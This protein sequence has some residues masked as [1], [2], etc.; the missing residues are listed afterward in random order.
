VCSIHSP[1][2][3]ITRHRQAS[4]FELTFFFSAALRDRVT[5]RIQSRRR[6]KLADR[7][8]NIKVSHGQQAVASEK[9]DAFASQDDGQKATER[10]RPDKGSA[11][12][13][14][15]R[16]LYWIYERRL[17][18]RIKQQPMPRHIGIILDG[19]RRHARK[20]GVS[21]PCEIYQRGAEKLDEILDWCAELRIPAVTLWVLSTENL[22]RPQAEV[23][24][25]LSAIETKVAALAHDPF[26]HQKRIHI[27]AIGCQ[28]LLPDSVIAAIRSAERATARYDSMT[29]TIA[30][31]YGGRE[32]VADAVRDFIRLQAQQGASLSDVIERITPEAIACHLYAANLPDPDLIIRTSGEI[33]LSG[34]LL[35]QSVHSEFYFTDVLWP[36]LRKVDFLRA[37]R[38]YQARSRRFGR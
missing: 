38:A 17:L 31:G 29:L 20:R 15:F 1:R 33:R 8:V 22:K 30:V 27:Q 23:L 37:I 3:Q 16:F 4:D 12:S 35:W 28:D 25:I 24:G 6:R 9:H 2:R 18:D 26:L 19:N 21:D 36:A 32:E 34:F 10:T 11:A 7:I 13:F 5:A 14:L